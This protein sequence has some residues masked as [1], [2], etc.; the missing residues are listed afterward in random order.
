MRGKGIDDNG[1]CINWSDLMKHKRGFTGPVADDM[2]RDLSG[3]GV[4]TL[5]GTATF[6]GAKRLEIDDHLYT[7]D[8]FLIATGARPQG[9]HFD[10]AEHLIDS[11][12]FLD[13]DRL[14]KR[15]LFVGGG[16]VSFE[17]A[18]ISARAGSS[19]VII[20]HG[21]RPLKGFDPDLVQLLITRGAEAGVEVRSETSITSIEKTQAGYNVTIERSRQTAVI[22][23]DLV[24]HG[25]GRV[26]ELSKLGLEAAGVA[27]SAKG[28][29]VAGHLPT[30]LACHSPPSQCSRARSRRRTC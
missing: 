20:D 27:F 16:F 22:E 8:H 4:E 12:T 29:T 30:R 2:E 18:H 10:G 19:P 14:P 7:A 5:H 1:L 9:L 23:T 24:V 11:T 28:V 15:I 13:L 6:T 21:T 26:A 25:A 3:N 17:F